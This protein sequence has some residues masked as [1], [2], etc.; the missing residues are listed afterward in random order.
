MI[1]EYE[2]NMGDTTGLFLLKVSTVLP[3]VTGIPQNVASPLPTLILN[4]E[5]GVE[6]YPS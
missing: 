1:I 3:V 2:I 4:I 5:G 6:L